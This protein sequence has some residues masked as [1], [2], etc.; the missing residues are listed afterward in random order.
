MLQLTAY[1]KSNVLKAQD[2]SVQVYVAGIDSRFRFPRICDETRYAF[3][4]EDKMIETSSKNSRSQSIKKE[5]TSDRQKAYF[6]EETVVNLSAECFDVTLVI[7][8]FEKQCPWCSLFAK[9]EE[10]IPFKNIDSLELK[11]F[12]HSKV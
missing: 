3:V 10:S 12:E 7:R 2:L 9:S 5:T 1:W 6:D 11:K 8:Y 4:F